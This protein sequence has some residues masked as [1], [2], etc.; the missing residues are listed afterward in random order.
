MFRGLAILG[1]RR[2]VIS[3]AE[4]SVLPAP[5][6]YLDVRQRLRA[7]YADSR[8]QIEESRRLI[9]QSQ[10]L[11]ARSAVQMVRSE[12]CLAEANRLL[13]LAET[14]LKARDAGGGL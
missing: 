8:R 3:R 9:E 14:I 13:V 1:T 11:L 7:D 10:M 2:P 5:R 4:M 6:A 12:E